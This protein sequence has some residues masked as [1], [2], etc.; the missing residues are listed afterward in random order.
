MIVVTS[1]SM[2]EIDVKGLLPA[3]S[4]I[5]D[6]VRW[7]GLLHV[8]SYIQNLHCLKVYSSILLCDDVVLPYIS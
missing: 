1:K 4:N 7:A 8:N 5:I 6:Q 3:I 2:P